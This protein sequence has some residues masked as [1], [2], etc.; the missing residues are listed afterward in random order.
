MSLVRRFVSYKYSL[1]FQVEVPGSIPDR[2]LEEFQLTYYFCV[3]S[4]ARGST[5]APTEISTKK[6]HGA[7]S[8]AG[9]YS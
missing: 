2:V 7:Q 4:L 3:H 5:Q 9:A 1:L 6:F 8:A